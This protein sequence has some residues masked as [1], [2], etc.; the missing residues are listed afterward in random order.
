VKH[1]LA[2]VTKSLTGTAV[3][4]HRGTAVC[5]RERACAG[6]VGSRHA[7]MRV[8]EERGGVARE[9]EAGQ[10]GRVVLGNRGR[11]EEK[12]G[13][14]KRKRKGREKEKG[15]EKGKRREREEKEKER[16]MGK[17]KRRNGGRKKGK[18]ER[19]K[20]ESDAC[21]RYS[22]WRPRLVGHARAT[23]ARCTRW[24]SGRIRYRL[25]D[26]GN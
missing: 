8:R 25:G 12:G 1:T 14:G 10:H 3:R 4:A 6:K 16:R 2:D 11:R 17:R 9:P 23:F 26:S 24:D 22:R 15:M 20:K 5:E 13:G 7:R 21:R 18:R 19:E